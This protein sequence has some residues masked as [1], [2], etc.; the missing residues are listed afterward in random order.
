MGVWGSVLSGCTAWAHELERTSVVLTFA[1]DGAF[2]LDVANDPVWLR[3]RLQSIPGPFA[4]RIVLWVDGREIRPETVEVIRGD[5]IATHRL[6]GHL[7][8][9]SRT[10]RWYYGL[11][12]DPYP[13]T[14][15]RADGRIIVEEIQGDAWSVAIDLSGQFKQTDRWPIYVICALTAAGLAMRLRTL[16]K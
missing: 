9:D 2:V 13:M 1:R 12:G 14:I 11:V 5:G 8:I 10:L 7:P 3:D 15:R 16:T 6:R 4:D